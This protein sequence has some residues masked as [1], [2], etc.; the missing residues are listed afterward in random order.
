MGLV[1]WGRRANAR[2]PPLVRTLQSDAHRLR[3]RAHCHSRRVEKYVF[4]PGGR[5]FDFYFC[6]LRFGSG[7]VGHRV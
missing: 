4:V 7:Q 2:W 6:A 1:G 5:L 3:S